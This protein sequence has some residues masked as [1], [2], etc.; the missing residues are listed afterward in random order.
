MAFSV[1]FAA[2]LA[3]FADGARV[4]KRREACGALGR[5]SGPN[6]SIVNGQPATECEWTWQVGLK[7]SA[8]TN[9]WCGGSLIHPEWVLTAAH[10]LEG[11]SNKGI[12]VVAGEHNL[13]KTSG[14]EQTIQS[15]TL[16]SHPSYDS[17]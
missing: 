7:S 4:A 13:R 10:C 3:I 2:T 1:A 8:G 14:D 15:Q 12:Y 9:P 16:Y 11:E 5:L 6:I 17:R